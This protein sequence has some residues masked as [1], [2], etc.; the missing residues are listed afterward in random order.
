MN[1]RLSL[2][3][4]ALLSFSAHSQNRYIDS[5]LY[6]LKTQPED[7]TKVKL[8]QKLSRH[9]VNSDPQKSLEYSSEG[10]L[11]SQKIKWNPGITAFYGEIANAYFYLGD[12]Q[13]ALK[14]RLEELDISKKMKYE[15][16]LSN[17][18]GG[19][20]ACY[21]NLGR[22]VEAMKMY[23]EALTM[24]DA[25]KD[26]VRQVDIL[27]NIGALYGERYD[28]LNALKC[29]KKALALSERGHLKVEFAENLIN[30]ANI[31]CDKG[32]ITRAQNMYLGALH[33][34]QDL[35]QGTDLIFLLF[36]VG[37]T[38]EL[39]ADSALTAGNIKLKDKYLAKCILFCDS[40]M[41]KA[42]RMGNTFMISHMLNGRGTTIGLLRKDYNEAFRNLDE[43]M[44]LATDLGATEIIINNHKSYYRLLKQKGEFERALMHYERFTAM[45][46]SINSLANKKSLAELQIQYDTEK[47]DAEN[48]TLA[49]QNKILELSLTNNRYLNYGI[50]ISMAAMLGL[51]LLLFRQQR[52]RSQQKY[53]LLQQKL[54]QSQM[55][56][57]FIFNSLTAIE[58]YIYEHQPKEA[59]NYLAQFSRLMRLMLENSSNE[60]ISLTT[61]TEMLEYYLLLQKLRLNGGLKY[62]IKTAENINP[63]NIMLPPMLLQPF[64]ENV[65]EH[66]FRG[67]EEEG[68]VNIEFFLNGDML[69]V[70]ITDNGIGF[71]Q[72]QQQKDRFSSHKSMAID[73]TQQRLKYLNRRSNHKFSLNIREIDPAKAN[74]GTEVL[75]T[76]P[77]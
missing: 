48:K 3:I 56:P 13:N 31:Y 24:A 51:G 23:F 69:H 12:Y 47:K 33:I 14:Y 21:S 15:D 28:T 77:V 40:A 19:I 75:F 61:E 41:R 62:S 60:K 38:Y 18:L 8:L 63:Q 66:G 74:K 29:F 67:L 6:V 42:K 55:D 16:N 35:N 4:S 34:L 20:G 32:Q 58:S 30:I 73:I 76:I 11:I 52:I 57:H 46:D 17:V 27:I 54:L 50:G 43:S 53:A 26:T 49:Q 72:S 68:E 2:F 59:G 71:Y 9:Y 45:N 10:L 70:K 22:Q 25:A 5:I 36:N 64:V 44:K 7:S 1:F 39:Q 37:S 65:I